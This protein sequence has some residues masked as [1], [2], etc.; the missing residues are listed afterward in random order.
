MHIKDPVVHVRVWW[1]MKTRKDPA[2]TLISQ[3][4][5]ARLQQESDLNFPWENSPLGQ[6]YTKQKIYKITGE[7]DKI[8]TVTLSSFECES[9]QHGFLVLLF[10]FVHALL[11]SQEDEMVFDSH[12]CKLTHVRVSV[13]YITFTCRLIMCNP[14]L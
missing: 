9:T 14:F 7:F 3:G 10:M 5:V 11:L 6:L 2:C 1:N 8:M 12:L 13:I 4:W